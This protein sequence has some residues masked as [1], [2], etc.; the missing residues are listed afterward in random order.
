MVFVTAAVVEVEAHKAFAVAGVVVGVAAV[1][2]TSPLM[3]TIHL[4]LVAW[5]L[6]LHHRV[7]LVHRAAMTQRIPFVDLAQFAKRSCAGQSW[8]DV[9]KTILAFQAASF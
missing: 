5:V 9:L 1:E 2:R 6:I 8:H 7:R 3:M 4:V